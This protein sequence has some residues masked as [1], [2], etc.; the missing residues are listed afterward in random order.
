MPIHHEQVKEAHRHHRWS[1]WLP[2]HLQNRQWRS[3]W[4]MVQH[5]LKW[6]AY[7]RRP[8]VSSSNFLDKFAFDL[9][10]NLKR[11]TC[12]A[13]HQQIQRFQEGP[14][15]G[16]EL[17]KTVPLARYPFTCGLCQQ[18]CALSSPWA[19]LLSQRREW[20]LRYCTGSLQVCREGTTLRHLGDIAAIGAEGI[21]VRAADTSSIESFLRRKGWRQD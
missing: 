18:R 10:R 7:D 15:D 13:S 16:W 4:S 2:E 20:C 1:H 12:R 3:T 19:L 14:T 6:P 9:L 17:P 21:Q 8:K 5:A 11:S